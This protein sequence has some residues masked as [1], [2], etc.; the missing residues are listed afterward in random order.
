MFEIETNFQKQIEPHKFEPILTNTNHSDNSLLT[1]D[2]TIDRLNLDRVIAKSMDSYSGYGWSADIAFQLANLY[3]AFL[4]LC[5]TYPNEVI[6]PIKE[7]DEFWHLHILDTRNYMAD[8]EAIFGYYLH[9]YPY[10]GLTG[11]S[12]REE[13][14]E[15]FKIRTLELIEKHFPQLLSED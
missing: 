10:A 15:L 5:K 11:S 2:P 3:R 12:S 6:V 13:D 7:V 9:H 14:E 8:C 4:F 1:Y